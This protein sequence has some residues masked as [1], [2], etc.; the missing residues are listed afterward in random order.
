MSETANTKANEEPRTEP[1]PTNNRAEWA[2]IIRLL[3]E[4]LSVRELRRVE[5]ISVQQWRHLE[6][7][8]GRELSRIEASIVSSLSSAVEHALG[9]LF[10]I[11]LT[12]V[13]GGCLIA[14]L[15]LLLGLWCPWWL[16]LALVGT[17]VIA[18]GRFFYARQNRGARLFFGSASSKASA[19]TDS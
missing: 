1:P 2:E 4:A 15:V 6:E 11:A 3:M 7:V 5:E 10:L 8:G 12:I 17:I 19:A 13:G 9:G 14:A 16:S 18:A